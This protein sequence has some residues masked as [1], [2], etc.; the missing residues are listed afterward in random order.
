MR[1][2]FFSLALALMLAACGQPAAGWRALPVRTQVSATGLELELVQQPAVGGVVQP[3]RRPPAGE[4]CMTYLVRLQARDGRWHEVRPED[5]RAGEGGRLVDA[6]AH[7][8]N[9]AESEPTWIGNAQ[10]E[11]IMSFL[12]PPGPPR[13]LFWQPAR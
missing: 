7:C 9:E 2:A 10:K 11:L 1:R 12:Q 8:D 5:F 13:T 4:V 6:L 3:W